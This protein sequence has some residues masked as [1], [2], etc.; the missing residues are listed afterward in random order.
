[1]PEKDIIIPLR[2]GQQLKLN[3]I[4]NPIEKKDV[5]SATYKYDETGNEINDPEIGIAAIINTIHDNFPEL[6]YRVEFLNHKLTVEL[7]KES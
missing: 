5:I 2:N 7:F 3:R 1:M 6:N 4:Y